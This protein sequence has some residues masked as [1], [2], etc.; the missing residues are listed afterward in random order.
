[1]NNIQIQFRYFIRKQRHNRWHYAITIKVF[2]F[3]AWKPDNIS[4]F[5]KAYFIRVGAD[6]ISLMAKFCELFIKN[7]GT[8]R[9]TIKIWIIG[10]SKNSYTHE[11]IICYF[12][13][14][15]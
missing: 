4:L 9:N 6:N 12:K 5:F 14:F 10:I 3:N 8:C 15:V 2:K 11:I 13:Q 7:L 1:M